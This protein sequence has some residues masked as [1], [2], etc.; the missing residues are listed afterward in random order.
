MT[1]LL[2]THSNVS[3]NHTQHKND[4][5]HTY[6][7]YEVNEAVY[8]YTYQTRCRFY[9]A[10][11]IKYDKTITNPYIIKTDMSIST[12]QV[13]MYLNMAHLQLAKKFC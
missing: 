4:T 12:S 9:K 6:K 10:M 5:A 11:R 8:R 7:N 2:Q 1:I 13:N 3:T